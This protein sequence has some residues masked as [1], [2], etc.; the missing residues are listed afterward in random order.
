MNVFSIAEDLKHCPCSLQ[1]MPLSGGVAPFDE[2]IDAHKPQN[3]SE[4]AGPFEAAGQKR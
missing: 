3:R 1:F 2:I 4:C